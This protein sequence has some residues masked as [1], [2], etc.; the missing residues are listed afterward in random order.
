[1]D[2]ILQPQ[3]CT[4]R[5]QCRFLFTF[6]TDHEPRWPSAVDLSKRVQQ[7]IHSFA[8][9]EAPKKENVFGLADC[10]IEPSRPWLGIGKIFDV[11][12]IGDR[13]NA[14]T[15]RT[16]FLIALVGELTDGDQSIGFV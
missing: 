15:A 9:L 16:Q 3:T 14:T 4:L 6:P 7:E 11:N 1:M 2:P 5:L 8:V 12:S 10:R 13:H